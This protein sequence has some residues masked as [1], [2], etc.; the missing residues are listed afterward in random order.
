LKFIGITY[1]AFFV[2]RFICMADMTLLICLLGSVSLICMT[3]AFATEQHLVCYYKFLNF[4]PVF[5]VLL[6][7]CFCVIA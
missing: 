4:T 2:V 5:L 3:F 6:A 7:I 1:W